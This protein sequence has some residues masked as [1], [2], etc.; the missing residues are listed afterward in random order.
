MRVSSKVYISSNISEHTSGLLV[1]LYLILKSLYMFIFTTLYTYK[2]IYM[3][4][5]Y[6]HFKNDTFYEEIY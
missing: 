6:K 1:N 3:K 2:F 4:K 5:Y